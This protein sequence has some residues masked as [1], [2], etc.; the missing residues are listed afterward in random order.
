MLNNSKNLD[1]AL[2][3]YLR[4]LNY[5]FLKRNRRAYE[6]FSDGNISND[7]DRIKTYGMES[8]GVQLYSLAAVLEAQIFV[9]MVHPDNF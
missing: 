8:E 4:A 5:N 2:I 3:G 9:L 6:P 7:L 1:A